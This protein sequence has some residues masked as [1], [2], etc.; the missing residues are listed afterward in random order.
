MQND[1]Q[2]IRQLV[3]TWHTASR[4]GDVDTVLSLMTTDVVFLV[5]GRPPMHKEEF[6]SLSRVPK[7]KIPPKI[8][9]TTEIQEIQVSGDLAFMWAK[10]SV[11]VTPP[12]GGQPIERAGH[13][14]SVL[15]RVD[16]R[17]LLA[18]DANL[19]ASVQRSNT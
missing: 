7:G 10:L 18:R 5:P 9:G 6:A 16:G 17:W 8:D 2:Q 19:L 14:L 15:R 12:D 11:V 4:A 13:T 1:E 3:S